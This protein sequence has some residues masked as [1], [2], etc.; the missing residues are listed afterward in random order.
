VSSYNQA[1]S[2]ESN[3]HFE[4]ASCGYRNALEILIKDYAINI[5]GEDKKSVVGKDLI[6]AINAY[7]KDDL[8]KNGA[9]AIRILGNDK[10][11]YEKKYDH[12]SFDALKKYVDSFMLY[13]ESML[14]LRNQ[15][16]KKSEEQ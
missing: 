1:Y 10:T 4:L 5:L 15:V 16:E 8:L 14:I 7:M 6:E 11:H 3:G 9:H 13:M 2:S 12:I